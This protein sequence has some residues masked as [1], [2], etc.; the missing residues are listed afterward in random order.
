MEL[1]RS[2]GAIVLVS[3]KVR[4]DGAYFP[5]TIINSKPMLRLLPVSFSATYLTRNPEA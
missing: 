1:T 5:S 3:P 4:K 2:N